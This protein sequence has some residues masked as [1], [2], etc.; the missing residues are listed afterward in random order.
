MSR[1]ILFSH[2]YFMRFDPKQWAFRQPYPPLGTIL[3][4]Q[5]M[6]DAGYEVKLFDSMLA[7]SPQEVMAHFESFQPDVFVVYD[8]GFNY[9]TKMCL[10]NMREAAWEM[11]AYAKRCGCQVFVS[12]SDSTDHFEKY[13]EH[14]ADVVIIGEAEETL[15]ELMDGNTSWN[16]IKGIVFTENG[17]LVRT[18]A[19]QVMKDITNLPLPA[20]DLINIEDYRSIWMEKWGYFSLNIATTRG[21]PYHCN[22]CAKPI[23]GQ[24]YAMR[25]P[26]QVVQEIHFLQEHYA[27]DHFWFCDDIFGM[28]RNWVVEFATL[29]ETLPKPISYKIQSRADLLVQE[30]YVEALA[31]SG[32]ACVWLGAESGSQRILDAMDKGTTVAQ[33]KTACNL[34]KQHGISPAFFIQ[35]GYSGETLN[36]L[37]QTIGLLN[38]CL[39]DDIG[40][41][42]SY[43][44]PGTAFYEQVKAGFGKKTNWTDSNDLAMMFQHTYTAAFY[45]QL[46]RYMHKNFRKQQALNSWKSIFQQFQITRKTLWKAASLAY[47]WPRTFV[48]KCRLTQLQHDAH[49][50]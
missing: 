6:R 31:K 15:R 41:S 22:W 4:A 10:T 13:L 44:L 34:L 47:Y 29:V 42:V 43:P 36:D 14:G 9:L 3:A 5:V 33:I 40:I 38:D 26:Q 37:K 19:R 32:C 39:P 8:D 25:T 48:E 24:S 23:Y 11:C 12:G 20:W 46:H 1:R 35:I 17:Q 7:Q 27:P 30:R 45:K 49:I 21:C 16:N 50:L 28:R 18:A 2:S